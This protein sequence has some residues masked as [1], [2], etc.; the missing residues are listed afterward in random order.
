MAN[1]IP[2]TRLTAETLIACGADKNHAYKYV[3]AINE[4]LPLYGLTTLL[5]VAHWLGQV[6]VESDRMRAVREYASGE[7]YEGRV[8][9][10]NTQKG[11]GVRF[12]GRGLIQLTGRT[13]YEAFAKKFGIDCV[14]HP[15][16]LEQPRW[17]VASALN[18]WNTRKLNGWA[19]Q[20]NVLAISQII[21]QGSVPKPGVKRALPNGY[22]DRVALVKR[23]KEALGD[24]Y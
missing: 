17:A 6:L 18:Y 1:P 14:N 20:D 11:D 3:D 9:L 19:D 5:R 2:V 23:C 22:H 10:G 8:S 15:E 21:N 24:I 16:I 12:K 4:L 7:A 13:N